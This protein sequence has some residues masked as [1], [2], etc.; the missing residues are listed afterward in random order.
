MTRINLGSGDHLHLGGKDTREVRTS[1]AAGR[2]AAEARQAESPQSRQEEA[3]APPQEEAVDPWAVVVEQ[4]QVPPAMLVDPARAE[5]GRLSSRE[6]NL[7]P[8]EQSQV[9]AFDPPEGYGVSVSDR[10]LVARLEAI[11]APPAHGEDDFSTTLDE[12]APAP[13]DEITRAWGT[14]APM[15][16]YI[17]G[18]AGSGKT[19]L[20][21]AW[22]AREK[23]LLLCA[24]TGIAAINLGGTTINAQ[25]GYFDTKSL[26]DSYTNGFL[27]ARLGKLWKAGV[28]RLILDEV[29]MLD[30]DQLT[31]LVKAIEELS[32]RGYVL[33]SQEW[34]EDDGVAAMGLTLVGD[35]AQLPP[36]KAPF[37]F[38]ST[39]WDR[40][41]GKNTITLTEIRRQADQDFIAA[42]RAARLG[43]GYKALEYFGPAL[44]STT[45]DNFDGPTLLAKNESVDRYNWLRMNR[46]T[47][48]DVHFVSSREGKQRSEWGNPD[49][50]PTTWGI[51][52]RLHLKIGALVMILANKRRPMAYGF[53]YVNGDLGTIEEADE[54]R[55]IAYIRL[56][57]TNEVVAVDY[58]R[59]EVLVPLDSARRKELRDKG[60]SHK[61]S[62]NGKWEIAGWIQYMPLR[63]AYAST[64]HKSQGLSLDKVQVNIRDAFF[65]SPGMIYVALSRARTPQGLRLVGSAA[66]FIERCTTD[67][68]LGPW[69]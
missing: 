46:L 35:F 36:V 33:K 43:Q 50:P 56:Q 28:R 20:V 57:R 32:G 41:I 51:P 22:A 40:F 60:E 11:N 9:E 12:S 14:A 34:D 19:F 6:S 2:E 17:A 8:P 16:T 27:T 45:D 30:G 66:A 48:R 62:D 68:R 44:Q 52:Q 38:E 39:E 53:E 67:P 69:L 59:R 55:K 10:D 42:L 58:V 5:V 61:I 13:D 63:V 37:A 54:E 18:P 15:F 64:V 7:R 4:T 24:T 29:S 3:V 49:K 65:K 1:T 23:G 26:Q 31:Y 21:K 47:G 25:L